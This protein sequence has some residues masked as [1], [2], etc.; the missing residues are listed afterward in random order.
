MPLI[1]V[2]PNTRSGKQSELYGARAERLTSVYS[3]VNKSLG[4]A[5]RAGMAFDFATY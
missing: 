5:P 4:S 1:V 3:A 2:R